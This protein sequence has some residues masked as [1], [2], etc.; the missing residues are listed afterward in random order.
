MHPSNREYV[1]SKYIFKFTHFSFMTISLFRKVLIYFFYW[2]IHIR[3]WE[4]HIQRCSNWRYTNSIENRRHHQPHQHHH[5]HRHSLPSQLPWIPRIILNDFIIWKSCKAGLWRRMF[6]WLWIR[7]H[8]V[9]FRFTHIFF[10]RSSFCAITCICV[11][12]WFGN[13]NEQSK[14]RGIEHEQLTICM[15]IICVFL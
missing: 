7:F 12:N 1:I 5:H 13:R 3:T 4:A 15:N 8:V 14:M 6:H 9:F 10:A 11:N 2:N